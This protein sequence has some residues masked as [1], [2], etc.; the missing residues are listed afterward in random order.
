MEA[1]QQQLVVAA[2]LPPVPTQS[3]QQI[4]QGEHV[5]LNTLLTNYIC[6]HQWD[7]PCLHNSLLSL[8][9]HHWLHRWEA[10]NIYM[11]IRLGSSPERA[12]ELIG[13]Q[14]L[15]CSANKLLSTNG[16]NM[17]TNFVP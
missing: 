11:S 6:G 8:K 14:R 10:W 5:A 16:F 3:H 13:C 9:F 2:T 15:I 4:V 1:L 17:T 7:N 12:L